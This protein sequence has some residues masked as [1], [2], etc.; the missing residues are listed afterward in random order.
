MKPVRLLSCIFL[1]YAVGILPQPTSRP[2]TIADYFQITKS[3]A[4]D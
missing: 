4:A 2:I 3:M 1:P